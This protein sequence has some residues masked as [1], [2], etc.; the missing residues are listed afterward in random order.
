MPWPGEDNG[1]NQGVQYPDGT[2]REDDPERD[3]DDRPTPVDLLVQFE[4]NKEKLDYVDGVEEF[5][6]KITTF[7]Q[8]NLGNSYL[9][10]FFMFQGP[11]SD[12]Q[13]DDG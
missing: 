3:E 8:K 1:Q 5:K 2:Q 9:Q 13:G 12:S 11:D 4:R 7:K 10:G 6:L